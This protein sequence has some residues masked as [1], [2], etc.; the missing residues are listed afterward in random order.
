MNT[1][2]A[3]IIK[4]T[5]ST[6]KR[7]SGPKPSWQIL[8]RTTRAR[9]EILPGPLRGKEGL[10]TAQIETAD[11]IRGKFD[12]DV[13]RH[14]A[15]SD[16]FRMTVDETPRATVSRFDPAGAIR[17]GESPA[18]GKNGEMDCAVESAPVVPP[19]RG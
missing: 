1:G 13:V 6:S 18:N 8:L 14:C 17:K 3:A 12:L 2:V 7:K 4:A 9:Q 19:S 15:R 5:A 11:V 16:V 10:L